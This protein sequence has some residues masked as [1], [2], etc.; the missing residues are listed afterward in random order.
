MHRALASSRRRN[1]TSFAAIGGNF[2]DAHQIGHDPVQREV[3]WRVD[4]DNAGILQRAS[5]VRRDD[6]ADD[7][8]HSGRVIFL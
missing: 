6:A 1:P 4:L 2:D 3:F 5:I 7:D 8:R